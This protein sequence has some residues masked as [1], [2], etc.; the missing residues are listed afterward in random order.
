MIAA[1]VLHDFA[2]R[3]EFH[4]GLRWGVALAGLSVVLGVLST[5]VLRRPAPVAGLALV[6]AFVGGVRSTRSV[7]IDGF[8]R[9]GLPT[10]VTRA[11]L[12]LAVAGLVVGLLAMWW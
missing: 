1:S 8:D 12:Y 2:N 6:I 10:D 11:F 7:A 4:E 9:S 5:V 3:H